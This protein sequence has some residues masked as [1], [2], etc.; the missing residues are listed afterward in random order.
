MSEAH[1]QSAGPLEQIAAAPV[2]VSRGDAHALVAVVDGEPYA[3]ADA[4]LHKGAS[5]VGGVCS[6]GMISCPSHWWRYDL[7]NG[8]LQGSAEALA[9]F[10]TRVVDGI[11]EV[12]L[13]DPAPSPSLRDVLL[14]HARAGRPGQELPVPDAPVG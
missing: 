10:Q 5:L 9:T 13:A 12:C 14:A 11:V 7:R 8:Q 2:R 4:C 6:D 1:W 3:V